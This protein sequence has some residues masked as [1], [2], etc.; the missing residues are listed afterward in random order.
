MR[1]C[2]YFFIALLTFCRKDEDVLI[3]CKTL[4]F[5]IHEKHLD[6]IVSACK[7]V[8]HLSI[9]STFHL[10]SHF[11]PPPHRQP[12]LLHSF[13]FLCYFLT[14]FTLDLW[15]VAMLI[16]SCCLEAERKDG[17]SSE[18]LQVTHTNIRLHSWIVK[19]KGNAVQHNILLLQVLKENTRCCRPVQQ[20]DIHR[21][22]CAHT[23]AHRH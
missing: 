9:F 7:I 4:V 22:W 3:S 21:V 12:L 6:W 10:S 1:P 11:S 23:D 16:C 15:L 18:G 19:R 17:I 20:L 13:L 5:H 14:G 2:V 8:F